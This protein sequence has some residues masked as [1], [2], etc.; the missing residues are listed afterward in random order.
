MQGLVRRLRVLR[1]DTMHWNG[2]G[3]SIRTPQQLRGVTSI[4]MRRMA[5]AAKMRLDQKTIDQVLAAVRRGRL[6]E[7]PSERRD[8]EAREQREE[9]ER[10]RREEDERE[11][12]RQE[13]LV[14]S[15]AASYMQILLRKHEGG[16]AFI[17]A[18]AWAPGVT[19]TSSSSIVEY[20]GVQQ[21][22]TILSAQY[23]YL[24]TAQGW[25]TVSDHQQSFPHGDSVW[26][27]Y[28]PT[29]KVWI[30]TTL[31]NLQLC[32]RRGDHCQPMGTEEAQDWVRE[33][34]SQSER[35]AQREQGQTKAAALSRLADTP[36][37]VEQSVWYTS[38]NIEEVRAET[39]A[40]I[41]LKQ[42]VISVAF[43]IAMLCRRM[44]ASCKRL[45]TQRIRG[46]GAWT[47]PSRRARGGAWSWGQWSIRRW[48][49][50]RSAPTG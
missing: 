4:D 20:Y 21:H 29:S 37:K 3:R 50:A 7:T 2:C 46:A 12:E 8:R 30:P 49:M 16:A 14:A 44:P 45:C 47:R 10:K 31:V 38:G 28:D 33:L 19:R 41:H 24:P 25:R 11:R 26:N 9:V 5:T 34:Q 40:S 1:L 35:R 39:S 48:Q 32:R 13:R 18:P 23:R 22:E 43:F 17:T 6:D 27:C 36:T 15:A 42:D